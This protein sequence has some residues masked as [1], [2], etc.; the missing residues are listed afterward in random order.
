[1]ASAR[2]FEG[3][4]EM[5]KKK[6]GW[7]ACLAAAVAAAAAGF[8]LWSPPGDSTLFQEKAAL[9]RQE[10]LADWMYVELGTD[11]AGEAGYAVFFSL[12]DGTKRAK[13]YTGTGDTPDAAWDAAQKKADRGTRRNRLQPQWVKVDLVYLSQAVPAA[14]LAETVRETQPGSF[15]YGVALDAD[16]S[17]ALLEA[18]LNG[19]GLWDSERGTLDETALKR[20]LREAKRFRLGGLPEEVTVFQCAGWLCDEEKTVYALSASGPDCGR[21]SV[22]LNGESVGTVTHDAGAW[23]VEQVRAD[24]TFRHE[25]YP[26]WDETGEGYNI[27][28]HAGALWALLQ[29]YRHTP[30]ES[31]KDPIDRAAEYL[32]SQVV[33][34]EQD[35][36][37]L[38]EETQEELKLGG[39]A[40]AVLAFLEYGDVFQSDTYEAPACALGRGILAQQDPET[41]TFCHVL[42]PDYHVKEQER[43]VYY[44]GEAAFALCRLYGATQDADYLTGAQ[45]A[46]EHF[47]S[48]E[49]GTYQDH[50]T[51]YAM[52]ELTKYVPE[53]ARYYAFALNNVQR[54]LEEMEDEKTTAPTYLEMLLTSFELYDR[55]ISRGAE[56]SG[57]QE[58]RFLAL[59]SERAERMLDGVLYPEYAMYF[60]SPRSVLHSFMVRQDRA[61]VR[62]DD[63]Q[64]NMSAYLLYQDSFGKLAY[65]SLLAGEGE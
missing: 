17:T 23:L 20:Y 34:R 33:Y 11:P 10:A 14:E 27:V 40:L 44:D 7:I 51:A 57:F 35:E 30:E 31:W 3:A 63:V 8:L 28:Y 26:Q 62:L 42:S 25:I 56:V 65:Y 32:L 53:D 24:G 6:K 37:Y 49:R 18:E 60:A 9:L 16:F 4:V 29:Q 59:I 58:G 13:V 55:M 61:R 21:R 39:S 64:H 2:F 50:W 54:Q 45:T 1:M 43:T 38:Y 19:A 5:E 12:S 22:T 41:G 52:N 46:A 15:R 47:L 36:A 48:A